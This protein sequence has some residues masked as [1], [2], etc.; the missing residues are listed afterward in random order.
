MLLCAGGC[1]GWGGEGWGVG[2]TGGRA[3]VTASD[4]GLV[5]DFFGTAFLTGFGAF[6]SASALGV[7]AA[8]ACLTPRLGL[9]PPLATRSSINPIASGSV[10]VS[11]VLS[12]G[13][14]ALTPPAGNTAP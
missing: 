6:A 12:L 7:F 4:F 5:A 11:G 3:L 1:G 2:V 13:I 8:L 10:M 14:V 9:P